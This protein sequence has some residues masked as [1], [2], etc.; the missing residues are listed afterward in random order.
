[1]FSDF[2]NIERNGVCEQNQRQAERCYHTQRV[3]F[4]SDIY[5]AESG[6]T[7]GRADGQ[8]RPRLAVVHS[9][10]SALKEAPTPR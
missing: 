5:D 6:R 1:M 2:R 4:E 10:Q 7:E 8:E 3:R 9:F